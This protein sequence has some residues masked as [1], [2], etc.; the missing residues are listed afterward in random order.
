MTRPIYRIRYTIRAGRPTERIPRRRSS[1]RPYRD[2]N[3]AILTG[4]NIRRAT[5]CPMRLAALVSLV[6]LF[7][8]GIPVAI[9]SLTALLWITAATILGSLSRGAILVDLVSAVG[10]VIL[11]RLVVLD[12]L[13]WVVAPF[14]LSIHVSRV[15]PISQVCLV[16]EVGLGSIV[17]LGILPILASLTFYRAYLPSN[18]SNTCLPSQSSHSI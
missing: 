17:A 7:S 13:F 14:S 11:T 1:H 2:G 10:L 12:I 6:T 16:I 9:V 4:R 15:G 5:Y 18:N 3:S 8:L